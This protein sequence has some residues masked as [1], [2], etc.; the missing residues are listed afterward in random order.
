VRN[1][2]SRV[3]RPFFDCDSLSGF[4]PSLHR[5]CDLEVMLVQCQTQSQ[6]LPGTDHWFGLCRVPEENGRELSLCPLPWA[7]GVPLPAL[8]SAGV[9]C[10][11]DIGV[12]ADTRPCIARAESPPVPWRPS[13]LEIAARGKYQPWNR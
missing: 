5:H 1:A 2:P 9:G 6:T 7:D 11:A 4:S 8:S 3:L 10:G 12:A 13:I